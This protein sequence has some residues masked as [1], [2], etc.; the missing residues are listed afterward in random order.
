MRLRLLFLF[1]CTSLLAAAQYKPTVSLTPK[2]DHRIELLS[3]LARL[4]DYDEYTQK[5]YIAYVTDI[6]QHFGPYRNHPAVA[7]MRDVRTRRGIGFDAVMSYAIQLDSTSL[8]PAI[9]FEKHL[10]DSRWTVED[11]TK[12]ADLIKQFYKDAHVATFFQQQADR[13][14]SAEARF[15]QVVQRV[16]LPWFQRYYGSAPN[17]AFRLVI[18][19]G[20]GGGN[21]GPHLPGKNGSQINYAI[22]GTWSVDS[23]GLAKYATDD[24]LPTVI[25]E[26]NHSFVNPLIDQSASALLP[27]ADS[28]YARV[29]EPMRKQAYANSKT[30]L[31]ESLVRASVVMYLQEHDSTGTTALNQLR[32]EQSRS[33]VW[34]DTLTGLLR[35]YVTHRQQYPTLQSF[36]PRH[37]AFYAWLAPRIDSVLTAYQQLCPQ[38]IAIEPFTNGSQSVDA[39]IDEVQVRFSKPLQPKRYGI[40]LGKGGKD[41]MPIESVLGLTDDGRALRLK[42]KLEPGHPYSFRLRNG[43]FRSTDGYLSSV[44]DVTFATAPA[45]SK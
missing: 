30:M 41:Q 40:Q 4:A 20:N 9:A 10:P 44:Y 24:Y 1:L 7:F 16:D 12:L 34:T 26:F 15:T 22:M 38:I 31:Y 8:K 23:T 3:I 6:E 36:M 19:L 39:G 25:H 29:Q 14:R 37:T 21:Y 2:V 33:F 42:V 11:A 43:G 45:P 32:E 28:V 13:Y 35:Q 27:Y 18:G 5:R 17:D